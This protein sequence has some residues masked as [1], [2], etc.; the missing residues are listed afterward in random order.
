MGS[1]NLKTQAQLESIVSQN[2]KNIQNFVASTNSFHNMSGQSQSSVR[3]QI[4]TLKT[5][6]KLLSEQIQK[7]DLEILKLKGRGQTN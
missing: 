2:D 7:K 3:L 4:N 6:C 1:T 5:K